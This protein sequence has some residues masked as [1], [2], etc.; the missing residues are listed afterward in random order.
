MKCTFSELRSLEVINVEDG[1]KIGYV[2]DMEIDC[3]TG[4]VSS[5]II[6]GR[7]RL[8]GI[9]GREEDIVIDLGDIKRIG[10]DTVLVSVSGKRL[11]KM[12]KKGDESLF[13]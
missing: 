10:E 4:A 9:M 8:M 2:D 3:D 12:P 13:D 5:L 11:C 6:N 7:A 1:S